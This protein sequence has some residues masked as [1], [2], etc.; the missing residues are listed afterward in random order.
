M[1]RP[2]ILALSSLVLVSCASSR[3]TSVKSPTADPAIAAASKNIGGNFYGTL[4]FSKGSSTLTESSKL[5]L[6]ELRE[7]FAADKR[8]VDEIKI[9]AWA[10]QEYPEV[11]ENDAPAKEIILA[12]E[13]AKN[14]KRYLSKELKADEEINLFNMAK[15]PG[16]LSTLTKSDDFEV[17]RAF[18]RSGATSV[19]LDDGSV[20]YSK[21]SKAIIVIDYDDEKSSK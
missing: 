1:S 7:T 20:S 11:V 8:D 12:H 5:Q 13:R 18:E 3:P 17:K 2:L 4:E 15:R 16:T 6:K 9:L 10:D 19:R 21:A 14:I